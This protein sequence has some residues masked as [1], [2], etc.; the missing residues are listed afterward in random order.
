[1]WPCFLFRGSGAS[2]DHRGLAHAHCL[3]FCSRSESLPQR[4]ASCVSKWSTAAMILRR[5]VSA[6][7]ALENVGDLKHP[8]LHPKAVIIWVYKIKTWYPQGR[9]LLFLSFLDI[10]PFWSFCMCLAKNGEAA[11]CALGAS[12][13]SSARLSWSHDAAERRVFLAHFRTVSPQDWNTGTARYL[14]SSSRCC[15]YTSPVSRTRLVIHILRLVSCAV[16]FSPR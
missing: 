14:C 4:V 8:F 16:I 5:L 9:K 11:T 7:H 12:H 3:H 15:D 1:M 6:I 2:Y 10:S 13:I